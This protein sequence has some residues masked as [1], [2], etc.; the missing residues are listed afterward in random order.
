MSV[1]LKDDGVVVLD[2][3]C[4]SEDAEPLLGHLSTPGRT[5]DWR[6]CDTAH[7]AVVQVLIA[8]GAPVVGPPR[9]AFLRLFVEPALKAQ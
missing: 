2:G 1:W 6:A 5:V 8:A 7:T 3:D 4:L 9:G